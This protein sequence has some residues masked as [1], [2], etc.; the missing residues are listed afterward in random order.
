MTVTDYEEFYGTLPDGSIDWESMGDTGGYRDDEDDYSDYS[1]DWGAYDDLEGLYCAGDLFRRERSTTG[2]IA[3][4]CL[5]FPSGNLGSTG[6]GK[7]AR[8]FSVASRAV[9]RFAAEVIARADVVGLDCK[10]SHLSREGSLELVS[11]CVPPPC[12]DSTPWVSVF[13]FDIRALGG[14]AGT[15]LDEVLQSRSVWKV[16]YDM[17]NDVDALLCQVQTISNFI[18]VSI[19]GLVAR[20]QHFGTHNTRFFNIEQ[21][22]GAFCCDTTLDFHIATG[23]Y[24]M[25][26]DGFPVPA[27][28]G[29]V[30]DSQ[31][32]RKSLQRFK[33]EMRSQMRGDTAR[34]I[35]TRRPLRHNDLAYAGLNAILSFAIWESAQKQWGLL[36]TA[37]GL[38]GPVA[39]CSQI[40]AGSRYMGECYLGSNPARATSAVVPGELARVLRDRRAA[41]GLHYFSFSRK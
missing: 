10:G 1:E 34:Q 38:C 27:P 37:E 31:F 29:V 17:R 26:R 36:T 5:G 25:R 39:V 15:G 6:S 24:E 32:G 33:D 19:V 22:F 16:V 3:P 4:G 9:A 23:R 28:G 21:M 11:I 2:T 14:V 35:W 30:V 20:E 8:V 41:T 7:H 18:D 40:S 13:V 12:W